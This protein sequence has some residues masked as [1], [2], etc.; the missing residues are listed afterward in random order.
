M[1]ITIALAVFSISL[2]VFLSECGIEAFAATSTS[3][4]N[5]EEITSGL[6]DP[7]AVEIGVSL[8][9]PTSPFYF[10]KSVREK[11]ELMFISKT[12]QKIIAELEFAQRRLREV[13]SLI[14]VG[15]QDLI[16]PMVEQYKSSIITLDSLAG[17]DSD[18][19]TE[20]AQALSRHLDI[21]QRFYDNAGEPR[22]K[23]SILSAIQRVEEHNRDLLSKLELKDQQKLIKEIALRQILACKFLV[24]ESSSSGVLETTRQLLAQKV[25]ACKKDAQTT[26][27]DQLDELRNNK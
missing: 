27:K 13:N 9:N 10:I 5:L 26:L 4:A 2:A 17:N 7:G 24:R 23:M 15:K 6:P 22:A 11:I 1:R 25:N 16:E 20:I 8:I 14:K 3:S 18:Y 19:K 12:S 21:L